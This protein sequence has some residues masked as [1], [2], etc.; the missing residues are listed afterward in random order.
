MS[1]LS[2]ISNP[3]FSEKNFIP[4]VN[5]AYIIHEQLYLNTNATGFKYIHALI[6]GNR[7][8]ELKEYSK[9]NLFK[10]ECDTKISNGFDALSLSLLF[11]YFGLEILIPFYTAF[12]IDKHIRDLADATYQNIHMFAMINQSM[13][14]GIKYR[15]I[16]FLQSEM[17]KLKHEKIKELK[18]RLSDRETYKQ[19]LLEEGRSLE[20]A[21]TESYI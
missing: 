17:L 5:K 9:T 12:E 20:E 16:M 13:Y 7:N 8:D 14:S 3:E 2:N 4:D 15:Q 19:A 11:P 10:T 18:N 1:N 21:I 6:L